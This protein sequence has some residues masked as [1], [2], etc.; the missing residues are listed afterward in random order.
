LCRRPTTCRIRFPF[1]TKPGSRG[2]LLSRARKRPDRYRRTFCIIIA[3]TVTALV[4]ASITGFVWAR[5]SV[6]VVVDGRASTYLT[7]V[8]DVRSL[9]AETRVR[10]AAGDLVNPAPE[11]ELADGDTIVVRHAIPVTLRLGGQPIRLH[12]VGS[13]VSDALVAAGFDPGTGMRVIPSLGTALTPG[14]VVTAE[15]VFVR[16][17]QEE[18]TIRPVSRTVE[19]TSL[20]VG[21]RRVVSRGVAGRLLRILETLVVGGREGTRVLKAQQVLRP[22][23]DNV[24][25]VGVRKDFRTGGDE[26]LRM[27]AAAKAP[28][29]AAGKRLTV[30]ATAYAPDAASGGPTGA[31]GAILGYGIIAVDPDVIP[32]GTRLYVP[33]YGYGIAADTGGA[34]KGAR[35]D[36][37]IEDLQKVDDWGVR[38]VT[39]T[40]L[41]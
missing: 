38:T 20:P 8:A 26:A 5:K 16:I 12:V 25:A 40:I 28:A 31:T 34:I 11:S 17:V 6:T 35:I 9:L 10:V 33:G 36:V 15:D 19:D 21:T 13:T 39:I 18:A 23:V 24:V 32:L 3:V 1:V 41:P 27:F 37:C 14:M 22:V 2:G 4:A 29:P 7:Q 30:V